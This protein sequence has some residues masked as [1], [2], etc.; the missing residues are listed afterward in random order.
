MDNFHL[1]LHQ[2]MDKRQT[3][4]CTIKKRLTDE[5]KLPVLSFSVRCLHVLVSI[6]QCLH[7][8]MSPSLHVSISCLHVFVSTFLE[9]RIRE[10]E[11]KEKQQLLFVSVNRNGNSK[12]QFVC[13]KRKW[14]TDV[15]FLGRQ[16][17]NGSQQSLIQQKCPSMLVTLYIVTEYMATFK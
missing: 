15:C 13:C 10:T 4:F 6:P 9:F 5:G 16:I 14:K 1:F 11:L 3:F 8:S 7:V 12:L 17:I 2:Q